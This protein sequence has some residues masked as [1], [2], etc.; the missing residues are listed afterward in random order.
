MTQ[1]PFPPVEPQVEIDGR[2]VGWLRRE[3]GPGAPVLL[4]H[5]HTGA[6]DDFDG[7]V[8]DLAQDR[9]VVAVDLPGHGDSGGPDDPA[10]YS[11]TA[12]AAWI[13][14]F[15]ETIGLGPHHLLGHSLGGLIVQRVAIARRDLVSLVLMGTGLGAIRPEGQEFIQRV[16][17]AAAQGGVAA[18]FAESVRSW[19]DAPLDEELK[20]RRHADQEYLRRRFA[21]LNPAAII[22][23][24]QQLATA[25][26]VASQLPAHVPVLVIHGEHDYA[27]EPPEQEELAAA[28]QNAQ[29]KVVPV[30]YHSPQKE[31]PEEWLRGIREFL[32]Q[33]DRRAE[34][35]TA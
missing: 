28:I 32:H 6:K 29:R 33:A 1:P 23:G 24:A 15:V 4:V 18:A 19:E 3:G 10:A 17:A 12:L 2:R 26:P 34:I 21:K 11:L 13:G 8:D 16:A 27:W 25:T 35:A 5:G 20:A 9:P 30:S 22:G 31:N 7:V 14:Q